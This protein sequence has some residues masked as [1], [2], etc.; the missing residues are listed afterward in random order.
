MQVLQL[1]SIS[2]SKDMKSYQNMAMTPVLLLFVTF[3]SKSSGCDD[4]E[5]KIIENLVHESTGKFLLQE[6]YDT[7]TSM[8]FFTV[9]FNYLNYSDKRQDTPL[10]FDYTSFKIDFTK[11][12]DEKYFCVAHMEYTTKKRIITLEMETNESS[13]GFF[14]GCD[15]Y[16]NSPLLMKI[17]TKDHPLFTANDREV[18]EIAADFEAKN[19]DCK[20]NKNYF[21]KQCFRNPGVSNYFVIFLL[22]SVFFIAALYRLVR[23]LINEDEGHP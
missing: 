22:V 6:T 14:F 3:V 20:V 23:S 9:F 15:L 16:D 2:T 13:Y 19:C 4:V 17:I 21:S 12:F 1:I 5:R 10:V 8:N 18:N 11:T 7:F